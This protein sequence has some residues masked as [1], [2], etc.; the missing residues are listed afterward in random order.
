MPTTLKTARWRQKPLIPTNY[1]DLASL[2]N[3]A[4][5]VRKKIIDFDWYF[6]RHDL[7]SLRRAAYEWGCPVRGRYRA[8]D[9]HILN[10][11]NTAIGEPE[12]LLSLSD[13]PN[14][15]RLDFSVSCIPINDD[16]RLFGH[17]SFDGQCTLDRRGSSGDCQGGWNAGLGSSSTPGGTLSTSTKCTL[18]SPDCLWH[19]QGR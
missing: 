11:I 13:P 14:T 8:F 15:A 3:V 17:A 19:Y 9:A 2:V 6:I 1:D 7:L 16:F 10:A 5:K 18:W 4:R 12:S